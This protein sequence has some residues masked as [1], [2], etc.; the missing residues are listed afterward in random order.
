MFYIFLTLESGIEFIFIFI[1]YYSINSTTNTPGSV[2]FVYCKIFK[3]IQSKIIIKKTARLKVIR[4]NKKIGK[5]T[6]SDS[7]RVKTRN[8]KGPSLIPLKIHLVHDLNK[9]DPKFSFSVSVSI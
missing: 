5:N 1:N 4:E 2:E 3:S 8:V 7:Q 9:D 6:Q